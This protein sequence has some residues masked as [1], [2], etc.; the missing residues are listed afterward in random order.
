LT[1]PHS[2][3]A[4]GY[5]M[6]FATND[7]TVRWAFTPDTA[8]TGDEECNS[9]STRGP[10]GEIV[11]A[12]VYS[13]SVQLTP[14]TGAYINM[15]AVGSYDAFL[16]V[17]DS[18]TGKAIWAKNYGGAQVDRIY[19]VTRDANDDIVVSGASGSTSLT[20]GTTTVT[21]PAGWL[22][23][24]FVLRVAKA[25]G[26]AITYQKTLG[27]ANS[28]VDNSWIGVTSGG[29]VVLCAIWYGTVDF[30]KGGGLT[31]VG[32]SSSTG[33]VVVVGLD[34]SSQTTSW[35]L[36]YGGNY[37]DACSALATDSTGAAII[38]GYHQSASLTIGGK[39]LPDPPPRSGAG[40][41]AGDLIKI[42]AQGNVAWLYTVTSTD[43]GAHDYVDSV[44]VIPG[45]N[46]IV[47]AGR[48]VG[49]VNLG[50]GTPTQSASSGSTTSIFVVER[51]P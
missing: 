45:S 2:G 10:S 25:P 31:S 51:T 36:T 28:S 33:D 40:S 41:G 19:D 12:C 30:G 38:G 21:P 32:T 46:K 13:G 49:N 47:Y 35:V 43:N 11:I 27:G 16:A 5:A 23:F 7:G 44:S 9:V 1:N 4:F 50:S 6:S 26:H 24:A 20:D 34:P 39:T 18:G 22:G 15:T 29:T 17:L 14:T 42:D 3:S 48:Y 37:Y 8:S